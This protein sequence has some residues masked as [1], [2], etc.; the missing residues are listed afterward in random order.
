MAI[1]F[2]VHE[3]LKRESVSLHLSGRKHFS[4]LLPQLLNV[5]YNYYYYYLNIEIVYY[6]YYYLIFT[7]TITPCLL[8][9]YLVVFPLTVDQHV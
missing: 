4:P 5:N 3:F 2:N 9:I 7:I 8:Y 6:Y 1:A